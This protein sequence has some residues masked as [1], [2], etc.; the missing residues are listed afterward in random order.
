M[1]LSCHAWRI[2]RGPGQIHRPVGGRA[3]A[4]GEERA[5]AH[6]AP[7]EGHGELTRHQL[8]LSESDRASEVNMYALV[9][10]LHF[11]VVGKAGRKQ[12]GS[13]A[14]RWR[15]RGDVFRNVRGR[16]DLT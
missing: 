13:A 10:Y 8:R 15:G 4:E 3:L 11:T 2:R 6:G 16:G 5:A 7:E 9:F 1:L 14:K 12:L